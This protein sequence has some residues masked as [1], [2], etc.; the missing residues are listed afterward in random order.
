M[1]TIQK[2]KEPDSLIEYRKKPGAYFDGYPNK[3]ELRVQL[4]REQRGLCCYCQSRIRPTG[5]GMKIEHWQSKSPDKYPQRQLDYTNLLGACYGGEK[6]GTKNSQDN[7]HCDTHKGESDL[8]FCLTDNAHPIEPQIHFLGDGAIQ[9]GN[10]DIQK[11]IDNVLK[12]NLG[13]LQ[14]NRKAVLKAFQQRLMTG[15]KFDA[16]K[17]LPNWD[18]SR[19]GDLE[20]FSQVVVYYLTKKL[21]RAS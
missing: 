1:R 13:H 19:D 5:D 20:P 10:P 16:A 9:S 15:K 3:E 18:G 21:R 4:A 8:C 6:P 11:D 12:L 14:E 17:E 7:F 2:E